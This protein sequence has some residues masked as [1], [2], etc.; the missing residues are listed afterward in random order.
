MN[1]RQKVRE[2]A[3][4]KHYGSKDNAEMKEKSSVKAWNS[5]L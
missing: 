3:I 1:T 4:Y 2:D 5:Y